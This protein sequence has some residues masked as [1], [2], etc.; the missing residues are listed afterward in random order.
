MGVCKDKCPGGNSRWE[1]DGPQGSPRVLP[2]V[3]VWLGADG[4]IGMLNQKRTR[5]GLERSTNC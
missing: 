4:V 2:H 3:G 1:G 5:L